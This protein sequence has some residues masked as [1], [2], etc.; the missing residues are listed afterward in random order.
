M[1]DAFKQLFFFLLWFTA[2]AALILLW[3]IIVAVMINGKRK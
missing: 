1:I 3:F 2:D